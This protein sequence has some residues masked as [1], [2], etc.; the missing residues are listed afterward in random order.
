MG[1]LY[2]IIK[3][4]VTILG[5]YNFHK[6][7][8]HVSEE[9]VN[10]LL[11]KIDGD[12]SKKY[13]LNLLKFMAQSVIEYGLLESCNDVFDVYRKMRVSPI[14]K[15]EDYRVSLSLL[16]HFLQITSCEKAVELSAYCCKEFDLTTF[17]PSLPSY[18]LLLCLASKLVSNEHYD[19]LFKSI[20]KGKFSKPKYDLRDASSPVELFQSMILKGTLHPSDPNLLKQELEGILNAAQL[21]QELQFVQ[22]NIPSCGT[23]I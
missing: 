18:Q 3:F 14:L 9:V 4:V 10:K 22:H 15:S 13:Q 20:D 1:T 12:Y 19:R 8:E 16:R 21:K 5:V 2:L 23:L 7:S 11:T 6:M 17:A